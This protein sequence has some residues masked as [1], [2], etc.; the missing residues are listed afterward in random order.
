MT[1]LRP[2]VTLPDRV[3][4]GPP[5]SALDHLKRRVLIEAIP[6]SAPR[7]GRAALGLN[8][9]SL[10]LDM[11]H[12]DRLTERL[13]LIDISHMSRTV[14]VDLSAAP[15]SPHQ[16]RALSTGTGPHAPRIWLPIARHT[17]RD[18]APVVIRDGHGAVV[19]RLTQSATTSAMAEGLSRLFRMLLDADPRS[20]V[21][22]GSGSALQQIRH[23]RH[24]ARWLIQSALVIAL[25]SPSTGFDRH[26]DSGQP[27]A[28]LTDPVRRL[29]V[30]ALEE[31][32]AEDFGLDR[33]VPFLQMMHLLLTEHI[34]VV[35][36][37]SDGTQTYLEYD[38]PMLPAERRR[39]TWPLL[40]RSGLTIRYSTMIPRAVNSYHVTL[41]L[42]SEIQVR[43]CILTTR[44]DE[45][46]ITTL[47]TDLE[48]LAAR[49]DSIA[50]D[51]SSAQPHTGPI[52]R[53]EWR[54]ICTRLAELGRR[55]MAELDAYRSYLIRQHVAPGPNRRAAHRLRTVFR[56]RSR[57]AFAR[58]LTPPESGPLPPDEGNSPSAWCAPGHR[59]PHHHRSPR[60]VT[61]LEHFASEWSRQGGN[62][63]ILPSSTQ[64]RLISD[65]LRAS[66]AGQDV[67]V[68]NDPRAHVAHL[69]WRRE[70][71]A[72]RA[73]SRGQVEADVVV[74]MGDDPPALRSEVG[75][76][77]T[78]LLVLVAG[79]MLLLEPVRQI[80][81]A[82]GLLDPRAFDRWF[83]FRHHVY[84]DWSCEHVGWFCERAADKPFWGSLGSRWDAR[85]TDEDKGPLS[86]ADAVV[87]VLLLVPGLLL[88]RLDA[89][90]TRTLVGWLRRWPRWTAYIAVMT[91]STL[92]ACV[93]ILPRPWLSL[94]FAFSI[95]IL[96]GLLIWN[97]IASVLAWI[98]RHAAVPSYRE[99]PAWLRAECGELR[100]YRRRPRCAIV[101]GIV[102]PPEGRE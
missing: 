58:A 12:V 53:E 56:P 79:L 33:G 99:I 71:S 46:L 23:E 82:F 81:E 4:E 93:A 77:L 2:D 60:P 51:S 98:A 85:V 36:V 41:E 57:S 91:T 70:P 72:Q 47:S 31:M 69:H 14:Q 34:T 95:V 62:D 7:T 38:A 3:L 92:A 5:R 21:K 37:P 86:S 55:R 11:E 100:P 16:Q 89:P 97:R 29:A 22:A 28:P 87:T 44:V 40:R 96:V 30:T 59:F 24:E 76:F 42:P 17:S 75:R 73:D 39:G 80:R 15:F 102:D 54:V 43:R 19:P 45:P 61:D 52:L 13:G 49:Q 67:T 18:L 50:A 68:D 74:A 26:T 88:T 25:R 101:H 84:L 32:F 90:S 65:N 48:A 83:G 8:L 64:L 27:G 9:L 20:Q 1:N 6:L 94:P 66:R 63:L 10:A 35:A 78:S